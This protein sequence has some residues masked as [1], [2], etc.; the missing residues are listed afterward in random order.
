MRDPRSIIAR[1]QGEAAGRTR[2]RVVLAPDFP[3]LRLDDRPADRK[4]HADARRL[5]RPVGLEQLARVLDVQPMADVRDGKLHSPTLVSRHRQAQQA[6]A[7]RKL[8]HGLDAVHDQVDEDLLDLRPIDLDAALGKQIELEPHIV[9]DQFAMHQAH[10]VP[11]Q[12]RDLHA[13]ALGGPAAQHRTQG[14]DD[15]SGT[16]VVGHD[17]LEDRLAFLGGQ[18]TGPEHSQPGLR[19]AEDGGKRLAQFVRQRRGHHRDLRDAIGMPAFRAQALELEFVAAAKRD[20]LQ[21]A[22][23]TRPGR[24]AARDPLEMVLDETLFPTRGEDAVLDALAVRPPRQAG[25][26]GLRISAATGSRLARGY[27]SAPSGGSSPPPPARRSRR[28][29]I[30]SERRIT[31]LTTSSGSPSSQSASVVPAWRAIEKPS[32]DA[33]PLNG[34]TR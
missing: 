15:L 30:E 21:R 1:G 23:D 17:V 27:T 9:H 33:R 3:A 8:V 2:A 7:G 24:R 11:H 16:L 12:L 29:S 5:G 22:E 10:D 4:P 32:N 6:A 25:L 13:L 28:A 31:G 18:G 19:I 26:D 20:V 14:F 34:S